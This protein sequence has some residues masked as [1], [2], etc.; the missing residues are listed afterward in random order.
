MPPLLQTHTIS[1]YNFAPEPSLVT[2]RPAPCQPACRFQNRPC[3]V[4][5]NRRDVC[6]AREKPSRRATRPSAGAP[7]CPAAV[8][9]RTSMKFTW[10]YAHGRGAPGHAQRHTRRRRVACEIA[11][12]GCRPG[13][14]NHAH[15]AGSRARVTPL[16]IACTWQGRFRSRAQPCYRAARA[17]PARV[18][19][20][21]K[22][23]P[24]PNRLRRRARPAGNPLAPSHPAVE[25]RAAA[26]RRCFDA[27]IYAT[28]TEIRALTRRTRACHATHAASS[29]CVRNREA[30]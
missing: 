24:S 5:A 17:V 7:P 3:H 23:L 9:T 13:H 11:R 6:Q 2:A 8:L 14:A 1:R 12:R 20:P 19:F 10:K 27:H 18:S 4:Q 15:H 22:P 29:C 30:R 21:E 26:S 25:A 28:H 16:R